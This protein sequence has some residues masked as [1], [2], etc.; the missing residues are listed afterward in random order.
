M[1]TRWKA[2]TALLFFSL[3]VSGAAAQDTLSN[4]YSI[5]T[6]SEWSRG[7]LSQGDITGGSFRL[8][9]GGGSNGYRNTFFG[10]YSDGEYNLKTYE[11]ETGEVKTLLDT[12]E[13]DEVGGA[14]DVTEDDTPEIAFLNNNNLKYYDIEKDQVTD[15]GVNGVS[16][17]GFADVD[18]DSSN[19][20]LIANSDTLKYYDVADSSLVTLSYSGC[21]ACVETVQ[22]V[23]FTG[24]FDGDGNLDVI[25]EGTDQYG[26]DETAV[27]DIS[28]QNS[29]DSS[30]MRTSGGLG[31]ISDYDNDGVGEA[32]YYW[33]A[34][35]YYLQ[36]KGQ[37]YSDADSIDVG[38]SAGATGPVVNYDGSG[39]TDILFSDGGLYS[40]D[41]GFSSA[42]MVWSGGVD[43]IGG[44]GDIGYYGVSSYTSEVINYSEEQYW[45][46]ITV[47]GL[48]RPNG[49]GVNITVETSNDDFATV[50]QG[51]VLTN[52]TLLDGSQT[53]SLSSLDNENKYARIR[54]DYQRG[55]YDTPSIDAVELNSERGNQPPKISQIRFEENRS[56][57][58]QLSF[59]LDDRLENDI[60]QINGISNPD[61]FTN[62]TWKKS[63]VALPFTASVNVSDF[64]GLASSTVAVDV[65]SSAG[66]L[67]E[68]S[69]FSHGLGSQRI[70]RDYL[71][72]NNGGKA[73]N[74]SIVVED[75]GSSIV[76]GNPVYQNISTGTQSTLTG[77]WQ[78]D[79]IT[80]EVESSYLKGQNRSVV[81]SLSQQYFYN[82]TQLV[83]ENQRN[84]SFTGVD[85]SSICSII[86]S[87]DVPSGTST[88]TESCNNESYSGDW[89][90]DVSTYT[91]E[92]G[93][94][95]SAISTINTQYLANQTGLKANNSLGFGLPAVDVSSQCENTTT[96]SVPPGFNNVTESCSVDSEQGDWIRN[97]QVYSTEYSSQTVVYGGSIQDTYTAVQN[98]YAENLRTDLDLDINFTHQIEDVEH[99][100]LDGN[101]EKTIPAV[102]GA[103][104]S[105]Y[106]SCKPGKE[107]GYIPVQKTATGDK[108]R[109]NL[110]T[111]VQ[112]Y[113]NLTDE[114]SQWIGIPKKRLDNYADRNA[115][116]TEAF[117]NGKQQDVSI[118]QGVVNG[119]EYVFIIV[120]DQYG[121]S[122]LHAGNHT[123]SLIYYQGGSTDSGSG[124]GSVSP[125][126][127]IDE[128]EGEDYSWTLSNPQSEENAGSGIQAIPGREFSRT[129]VIENQGDN[130]VTLDLQCISEGNSCRWVSVSV[131][132]IELEAGEGSTQTFQVKGK[133]PESA[134]PEDTFR[135][136]IR[137][138]DPSYD[139]STPSTS[140]SADADY[141]VNINPFLGSVIT[142]IDKI[143]SLREI[144]A[145]WDGA[146]PIPYPFVFIPLFS[147]GAVFAGLGK[148]LGMTN[149]DRSEVALVN[150]FVSFAVFIVVTLVA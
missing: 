47:S 62:Q 100:S 119:T 71:V 108:T 113:T 25:I 90:S 145:P 12:M 39:G 73:V 133:V 84:F 121:N 36:E 64:N 104:K 85:I 24:D 9:Y 109:Y 141:V 6:E 111:K 115:G 101:A 53:Y 11:F 136:S 87:A 140:G 93:Q 122:S 34:G 7:Q 81:S 150:F 58:N 10:S 74:Y 77:I 124:S 43:S 70:Y 114:Q 103:N 42:D 15:T 132:R 88:V 14:A 1:R 61:S 116:E 129:L 45:R 127:V 29:G 138:S 33:G 32:I 41:T 78:G 48:S 94:N 125:G 102:T 82:Q 147:G 105:F 95:S 96:T 68:Q 3:L 117:V 98:I 80:G 50:N 75:R 13:V 131:D 146:A 30:S 56:G 35:T 4:S 52:S 106:Q 27:Y 69:T 20:I 112:V 143:L 128:V 130:P 8:L 57:S 26:D 40:Y 65:D 79:W 18:S 5:D 134:T 19:E 17:G 16:V 135:F 83:A 144:P 63:G 54:I 66:S 22:S 107:I 89:I 91:I 149:F 76:K 137:V 97:E 2:A 126:T 92:Q 86:T 120:G 38:Y 59:D 44:Y 55:D 72:S 28:S 139:E 118:D 148:L 123:A 37:I 142:G 60:A 110:T 49:A 99:C 67:A 46:N 51:Q 21:E 23:G 31:D